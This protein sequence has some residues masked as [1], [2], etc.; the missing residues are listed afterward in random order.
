[1]AFI[2]F[3]NTTP[4]GFIGEASRQTPQQVDAEKRKKIGEAVSAARDLMKSKPAKAAY[5][6][7]KIDYLYA[8]IKVLDAYKKVLAAKS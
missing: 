3:N 5:Y 8:K 6:K 4:K 1:M 2:S 7:A